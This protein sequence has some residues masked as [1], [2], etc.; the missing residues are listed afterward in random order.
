MNIFYRG[1]PALLL[2]FAVCCSSVELLAVPNNRLA[3]NKTDNPKIQSKFIT[4][5]VT[6][7]GETLALAHKNAKDNAITEV[8]GMALRSENVV[9]ENSDRVQIISKI[10]AASA[11]YIGAYKELNCRKTKDGIFKVTASVTVYNDKLLEGVITKKDTA[12]VLGTNDHSDLL[13]TDEERRRDDMTQYIV[14]YMLD[15]CRIWQ[16]VPVKLFPE[17]DSNGKT[18]LYVDFY[19]GTTQQVY[20]QYLS[21]LHQAMQRINARETVWNHRKHVKHFY[22]LKVCRNPG[23]K[24]PQWTTYLIP[25]KFVDIPS[26]EKELDKYGYKITFDLLSQDNKLIRQ[27]VIGGSFYG[28]NGTPEPAVRYAFLLRPLIGGGGPAKLRAKF[29]MSFK[30]FSDT[31]E[32]LKVKKIKVKIQPV[33]KIHEKTIPFRQHVIKW[34]W[35]EF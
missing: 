22:P 10:H 24:N 17:Y 29:K 1:F 34:G 9:L 18:V 4:V 16:A 35:N 11:G 3:A 19:W 21:R 12:A 20:Q 14:S 28:Y 30:N 26:I 25:L 23:K 8:V 5:K 15:Y 32:M 27:E 7:S 13:G 33:K 31:S 6:G 2:I